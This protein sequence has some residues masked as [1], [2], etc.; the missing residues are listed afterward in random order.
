MGFVS[1]CDKRVKRLGFIDMQLVKLSVIAFT[2][3]VA[4]A[5]PVLL[6]L[7]W[8]WYALVFVAAGIKPLM[9]VFGDEKND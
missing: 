3:V 6:S 1:W 8:Y 5:W 9:S 7:A 2:L 4:K